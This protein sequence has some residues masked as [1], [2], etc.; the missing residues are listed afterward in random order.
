MS[1]V[2]EL[3]LILQGLNSCQTFTYLAKEA[4]IIKRCQSSLNCLLKMI[5]HRL[6]QASIIQETRSS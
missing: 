2:L 6:I 3:N 5:K 4:N 1:Q